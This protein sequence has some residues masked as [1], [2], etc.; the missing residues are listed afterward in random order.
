[1][2][3]KKDPSLH[4]GH[5]ERLIN[6]FLSDNKFTEVQLVELMLFFCIPRVDTNE[7]AHRLLNE[8]GSIKKIIKAAP[9]EVAKIYGM[10]PASAKRL[11][12]L[13]EI[14][15]WYEKARKE[16]EVAPYRDGS[17][18][19]YLIETD[20]Y[21]KLCRRDSKHRAAVLS[22][23]KDYSTRLILLRR[24]ADFETIREI[25]ENAKG[26]VWFIV[27]LSEDA[28]TDPLT[29]KVFTRSGLDDLR[30]MGFESIVYLF[31]SFG[32]KI[33]PLDE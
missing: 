2:T 31:P 28:K 10:G 26:T 30:D 9:E 23:A 32:L 8:F 11:R 22:F 33:C 21:M 5:R 6:S 4:K 19:V 17:D 12:K 13:G 29:S 18:V 25:A 27:Y 3:L 7:T 20:V 14:A 16:R 24:N 1:M 15:E